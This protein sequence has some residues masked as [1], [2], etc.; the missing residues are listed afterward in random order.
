MT[1]RYVIPTHKI[2]AKSHPDAL[3][4]IY[5]RTKNDADLAAVNTPALTHQNRNTNGHIIR[6]TKYIYD[7][8]APYV[9]FSSNIC[10]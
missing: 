7:S 8:Y 1:Y 5:L 3:Y 2:S 6:Q 10:M 4:E 9:F